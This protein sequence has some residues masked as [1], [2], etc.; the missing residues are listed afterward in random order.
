MQDPRVAHHDADMRVLCCIKCS[1]GQAFYFLQPMIWP[2]MVSV[3]QI[4]VA[5]SSSSWK[6]KKQQSVARSF[7]EAKYQSMADVIACLFGFN[8]FFLLLVSITNSQC[9][10]IVTIMQ[11]FI[12]LLILFFMKGPRILGL[13]VILFCKIF[14]RVFLLLNTYGLHSNFNHTYQSTCLASPSSSPSQVG[15]YGS[16]CSNLWGRVNILLSQHVEILAYRMFCYD[17]A[18]TYHACRQPAWFSFYLYSSLLKH[19]VHINIYKKIR[20]FYTD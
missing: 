17:I 10:Y 4:G 7:A 16:S 18:S 15:H 6:T 9:L 12:L 1:L 11:P 20:F 2:S 5:L 13:T 19:L 14:E 8:A 3:I